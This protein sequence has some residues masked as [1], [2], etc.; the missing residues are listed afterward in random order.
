MSQD[1]TLAKSVN[2]LE[3]NEINTPND[4]YSELIT[5]I[6]N[7]I[8]ELVM[9]NP[10][11][12]NLCKLNITRKLIKRGIM[13]ITYGVTPYG[14]LEQLRKDHFIKIDMVDN[15]NIYKPIDPKVGNVH[16]DYKDIRALSQIIYDS[17]FIVHPSLQRIMEYFNKVV[18][19]LNTLKLPIVW[20]TPYGLSIEQ[21]Y[22]KFTSYD[23]STY[24]LKKRYKITLNKA[25]TDSKGS[26]LINVDKQKLAFIP[27]FV[28]SMD[29]SNIVLLFKDINKN[30]PHLNVVTVHDCFGCIANNAELMSQLVKE[31]FIS[32]YGDSNF[33]DKFH[34]YILLTISNTYGIVD[35]N[36]IVD[37]D[38]DDPSMI[39]LPSKPDIGDIDLKSQLRKSK[40]FLN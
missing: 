7:R 3:S 14:I 28:H 22:V 13:T 20:L 15:H 26:Y 36:V 34:K 8:N 32:I 17:L 18:I 23:I 29:G 11:H 19:L 37:N 35:N 5:P 38:D 10:R 9:E 6:K 21:K 39:P 2:I 1:I 12:Y 25:Y 33:I 40:Y 31:S 24:S 27:N 4:V 16:L 30:Y